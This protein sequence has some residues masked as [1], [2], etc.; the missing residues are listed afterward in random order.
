MRSPLSRTLVADIIL[1]NLVGIRNYY[2]FLVD[3]IGINDNSPI[4]KGSR[5]I[6]KGVLL[7]VFI[8]GI[9]F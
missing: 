2:F 3:V 5:R 7:K 1:V 4:R 9:H 6:T 8:K